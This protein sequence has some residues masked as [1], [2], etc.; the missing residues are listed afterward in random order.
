MKND[1]QHE[2]VGFIPTVCDFRT[3]TEVHH[4]RTHVGFVGASGE[5]VTVLENVAVEAWRKLVNVNVAVLARVCGG[6]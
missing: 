5:G 2:L 1:L 3:Q 6:V 4:V